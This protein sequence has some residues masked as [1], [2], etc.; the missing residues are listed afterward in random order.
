M[1]E[2][3]NYNIPSIV[4]PVVT[5][6]TI[7]FA[8]PVN[9]PGNV[10]EE[11]LKLHQGAGGFLIKQ[12]PKANRVYILQGGG[13]TEKRI[14]ALLFILSH[15]EH[16]G[17]PLF[18]AKYALPFPLKYL[19]FL[20]KKVTA[21]ATADD[22]K[23]IDELKLS[24]FSTKPEKPDVSKFDKNTKVLT[25][26]E[27]VTLVTLFDGDL[28]LLQDIKEDENQDKKV[29]E[30]H[31][32]GLVYVGMKYLG[33]NQY[34]I[35]FTD[36]GGELTAN[37]VFSLVF[38]N[39]LATI[40]ARECVIC[41]YSDADPVEKPAFLSHFPAD[42]QNDIYFVAVPDETTEE[43][44]VATTN[45]YIF[46]NKFNDEVFGKIKSACE[47]YFN[48]IKL[49]TCK[50]CQCFYAPG[51][52]HE[53]CFE[54]YHKGKQIPF[55]S[56]EMEEVD[57]DEDGEPITLVNYSCCGENIKGEPPMQCG[58]KSRGNHIPDQGK[59]ISKCDIKKGHGLD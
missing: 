5:L 25:A 38:E 9:L 17:K 23:A 36:L 32:P 56:G 30:L 43:D 18:D 54:F 52:K 15:V 24:L 37:A 50:Q 41:N 19:L 33:I 4:N 3:A 48:E 53:E 2:L 49:M 6:K 28:A 59:E 12:K 14:E 58:K 34:E 29:F 27:A 40:K 10:K 46:S 35:T 42:I 51:G 16:E 31:L 57:E 21:E 7:E 11:V 55:E 8:L 44:D 1:A 26:A 45:V 22:I 47:G 13:S 39:A 20:N